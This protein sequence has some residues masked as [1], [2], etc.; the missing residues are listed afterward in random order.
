MIRKDQ[1]EARSELIQAQTISSTLPPGWRPDAVE[2][3]YRFVGAR[4][5][6]LDLTRLTF[7]VMYCEGGAFA[8]CDFSETIIRS[9]LMA[10]R[11]QTTYL[12]CKFDEA[13]LRGV[14]PGQARFER[15]SFERTRIDGWR[16]TASEFV[17]CRFTGRIRDC[18][19]W[20]RPQGQYAQSARLNPP[21]SA[22]EF[23]DNDFSLAEMVDVEFLG[24]LDID[25]QKWPSE[26]YVVVRNLADR[27]ARAAKTVRDRPASAEN[28]QLQAVLSVLGSSKFADQKDLLVGRYDV[29]SGAAADHLWALLGAMPVSS[30]ID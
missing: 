7:D 21:R 2:A 3:T 1:I 5:T 19:F 22:N 13:D 4:Q 29:I 18:Q 12:R 16:S 10:G 27:V 14:L 17:D 23:R 30:T 15:C 24:G 28:R 25:A 20:G 26:G 6:R 9:G 8:D 11:K